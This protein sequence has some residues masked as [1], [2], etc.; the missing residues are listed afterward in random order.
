MFLQVHIRITITR[1]SRRPPRPQSLRHIPKEVIEQL[2]LAASIND[3]PTIDNLLE[4]HF[5]TNTS[6]QSDIN[7]LHPVLSEA[8]KRDHTT[9]VTKLLSYSMKMHYLPVIEAIHAKAKKSLEVFFQN[10]YDINKPISETKPTVF[11][12]PTYIDLTPISFATEYAPPK[13][14]QELL[15]RNGDVR[16]GEVLQYALDRPTDIVE[17]LRMLIDH[18]APLNMTIYENH[19]ASRSLYPF[20][21]LGTPLHKAAEMGKADVVRFL[22]ERKADRNIRDQKGQTALQCA[23]TRG[24]MEVVDILKS[25]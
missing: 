20:M 10:G 19:Q 17:V 6:C 1:L 18:G 8:L 15:N 5:T 16:R 11:T 25:I 13:L 9:V 12:Y 2:K 4:I 3:L 22:L 23:Q 14:V 7:N 24:H 21:G